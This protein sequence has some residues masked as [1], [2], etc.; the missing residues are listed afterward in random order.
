MLIAAAAPVLA[1]K[2]GEVSSAE[3]QITP[4]EKMPEAPAAILFDL[5]EMTVCF[6]PFETILERHVRIK[7]FKKDAGADAATIEIPCLEKDRIKGLEAQ[8]IS[9]GGTKTPVKDIFT[10]KVDDVKIM[11]F[12]FPVIEDGAILEYRY[13]LINERLWELDPWY[14]QSE[15]Y[16][17][18]SHLSVVMHVGFSYDVVRVNIPIAMQNPVIKETGSIRVPTKTFIWELTDLMPAP[19]EPYMAAKWD[20]LTSLRFNL[21]GFS[22]YFDSVSFVLTWPEIGE[23]VEKWS[24]RFTG[25]DKDLALIADSL[26]AGEVLS[27]KKI[28]LLYTWIGDKIET[29]A[30]S[31][32]IDDALEL[33]RLGH[34]TA[35][36]K[37]LAL[38]GLLRT[39]G[40]IAHP[41]FIG[42]R[43]EHALFN[44]DIHRLSQ[45]DRIL[46]YVC[47]DSLG[48]L[49]DAGDELAI[50]PYLPPKDLVDL[51]LLI[52][53]DSTGPVTLQH[54]PRPSGT[55]V[56]SSLDL[57]PDGS[58]LCSANVIIQGYDLSAYMKF[59]K[60]SLPAADIVD[61]IIDKSQVE[62]TL[63]SAVRKYEP[64]TDQ[65]SFD[66]ILEL[67]HLG[68]VVDETV[69]FSPFIT[70]MI[71]GNVFSSERRNFPIDFCYPRYA[72][73]RTFVRLSSGMTAADLPADIMEPIP[74]GLFS[75]SMKAAGN[76]IEVKAR[77]DLRKSLYAVAEYDGMK[78]LFE[79]MSASYADKIAVALGQR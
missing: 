65:L 79:T 34:G 25:H 73:L 66:I 71:S 23:N 47:D 16:T 61:R 1:Q 20:F 62:Y 13:R 51:G 37:N 29:R 19:D 12:T 64:E 59:I 46:C 63:Q 55:S 27:H 36:E 14:F 67:P 15:W 42:R 48:G 54:F 8:T 41:V 44:P 5:G 52:N 35:S 21:V 69:F 77:L 6:D 4:P 45:F 60:D 78:K 26:C 9:P 68:A 2:W 7:I 76:V 22:L 32:D 39:Q 24:R 10:K 57:R 53:G 3:W 28:K 50:F 33:L 49:Y 74:D 38:A 18:R 75:R 43:D 72:R 56:T 40:I 31:E 17:F 70:E 30:E 58:A 11:T